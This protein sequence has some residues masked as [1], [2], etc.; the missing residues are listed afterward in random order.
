MLMLLVLLL[1]LARVLVC[2]YSLPASRLVDG[3]RRLSSSS[4]DK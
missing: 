3:E 4:R 1:V 2:G